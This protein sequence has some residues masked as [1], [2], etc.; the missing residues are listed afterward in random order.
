[1][2]GPVAARVLR[3]PLTR[4]RIWLAFAV[5][6][7]ADGIQFALGAVGWLFFDEAIDVVAMVLITFLI[8]FHPL[9]L[10]TFVVEFLPVMDMVPTWTGCVAVVV[11]LRRKQSKPP[12]VT[13][14]PQDSKVI[15]V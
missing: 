2:N 1:M 12:I 7:L 3:P 5:A 13:T 14:P 10:P 11:A 15:D 4:T 9:F 8:G 6:L